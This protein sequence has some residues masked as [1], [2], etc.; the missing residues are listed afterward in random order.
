MMKNTY[1]DLAAALKATRPPL[2][3][4]GTALDAQWSSDVRAVALVLEERFDNFD[5]QR[6]LDAIQCEEDGGGVAPRIPQG[7]EVINE[8]T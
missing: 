7:R 3:L 1:L 8:S 4:Q 2:L 6:F 5:H